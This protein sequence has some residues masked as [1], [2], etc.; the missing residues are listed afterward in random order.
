MTTKTVLFGTAAVLAFSAADA[1]A[2]APHPTAASKRL[3]SHFILLSHLCCKGIYAQRDN[4]NGIGIV[5]QNFT[6]PIAGSFD[7]YDSQ[8]ADD[9]P[10][11]RHA[12]VKEVDADGVY[13]NGSGPA[14]SYN[15]TFYTDAGGT[16]GTIVK[17]C[18]NASYT[19]LGFGTPSI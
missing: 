13:F 4:D 5:S 16:P 17:A 8:G 12:K 15:V 18:N 11:V 6:D 19:D 3:P 7:I 10:I 2:A 1:S 9:F 14:D